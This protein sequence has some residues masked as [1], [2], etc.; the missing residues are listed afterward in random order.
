MEKPDRHKKGTIMSRSIS[1]TDLMQ[2]H[3]DLQMG[4]YFSEVKDLG[5]GVRFASSSRI[6]DFYW[7]YAYG[8]ACSPKEL[9][10]HINKIRDYSQKIERSSTIY[11]TPDTTPQ[12]IDEILTVKGTSSEVWM[13][14]PPNG[15][16]RLLVP[17]E[18]RVGT[19]A[20]KDDME[21]FIHV[22][23]D[24]YGSGDPNS[25][26]YS[27]LPEEYP[28]SIGNAS[29]PPDVQ[30]TYFLAWEGDTPVAISTIFSKPPYAGLYNV[31]TVHRVRRKHYGAV[32]SFVAVDHA[33][34]H[35]SEI[36]FLQT[37]ADSPVEELYGKLGFR[38]EF[39]GEFVIL[40]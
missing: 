24:A 30:V 26:G 5:A 18:L 32:M 27:G 17:N 7:N 33:L 39:L 38:R 12:H 36:I 10:D 25:P 35:G 16:Q 23:R 14:L 11:V 22:F 34:K 28:E 13:T 37:E 9:P 40:N 20:S 2:A 1:P 3:V 8:L 19:V 21:Q 4:T 15:L 6:S 31:G 29:P